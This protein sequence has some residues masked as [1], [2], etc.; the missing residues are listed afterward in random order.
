MLMLYKEGEQ[1]FERLQE[2]IMKTSDDYTL[3]A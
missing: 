2:E 3:F 1:A